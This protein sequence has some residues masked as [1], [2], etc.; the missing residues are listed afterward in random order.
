MS[1]G[2][3]HEILTR[4]Q[5][6]DERQ[7]Q[8]SEFVQEYERAIKVAVALK[9]TNLA[10]LAAS[11]S[12]SPSTTV[13][14][15]RPPTSASEGPLAA[16]PSVNSSVH[17]AYI[18]TLEGQLSETKQELNEQYKVQSLNAQRLLTLTDQVR[19]FERRERTD[20]HNELQLQ[21]EVES[22]RERQKW[23]RQTVDEKEK[24]IILQDEI[25]SLE[26][27]LDQLSIQNQNLKKDNA[28]LLSRWLQAKN[29]EAARMND[30]FVS[31]SSKLSSKSSVDDGIV[32]LTTTEPS[33]R[34]TNSSRPKEKSI[35]QAVKS[36]TEKMP[37]SMINSRTL[38][39]K[40][41][42]ASITSTKSAT[43]R[44]ETTLRSGTLRSGTSS[45][46]RA[47]TSTMT[48]SSSGSS[49]GSS[50]SSS[51]MRK[52]PSRNNMMTT[53]QILD[54]RNKTKATFVGTSNLASRSTTSLAL[55]DKGKAR[56]P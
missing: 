13:P 54:P 52:T 21:V 56:S 42:Q 14:Q 3:Q 40:P 35:E 51:V 25:Q 22:L 5:Q 33:T 8:M 11:S 50:S 29:E 47:A 4:L 32:V 15:S 6:R 9:H 55:S 36:T 39:S 26:L 37:K 28:A 53:S 48:H 38:A 41:S 30:L 43:P 20:K 34:A 19:E 17:A 24:Q 7:Q 44:L 1:G 18:S 16:Q 45:S 12:A 27:E 23:W 10:L 49:N 46:A 31:E 2:W